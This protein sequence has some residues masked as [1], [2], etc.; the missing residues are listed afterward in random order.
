MERACGDYTILV[1]E[2]NKL[3]LE[4]LLS[5]LNERDYRIAAATTGPKAL[6]IC[7]EILPD[8]I[9]MDVHMPGMDGFETAEQLL[10]SERT[11]HIPILFTSTLSDSKNVVRCFEAG[12]VDYISKPFKK[13]ELLA[14]I[15]THLSLNKLREQLVTDRDNLTS[16]L[17]NMLPSRLINTLKSGRFPKPESVD[18]A[19]VLFTDFKNFSKLSHHIGSRESVEHLNLIYF[20]FD[21]IVECF[22]LERVKTIGDAYFAVGGINT[23]PEN[24]FLSPVLAALKMQ[25]FISYYNAMR[26]DFQWE[27]R[28]GVCTGPVTSGIIGYQKIAYDV[29]GDTVNLANRLENRC[30]PG[31]VAIPE[32]VYERIKPHITTSHMDVIESGAWGSVHLY[33]CNGFSRD[34]PDLHKHL[35]ESIN[36]KLMLEEASNKKSI[37]GKIFS[38]APS[39][40]Q[41]G[42]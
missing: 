26:S 35:Y 15:H 19:A 6:K 31:L 7:N 13:E 24:I 23:T 32:F 34:L 4:L 30:E 14:R 41:N 12:G 29:W 25:E 5:I 42:H 28:V 38:L 18:N 33:Q 27:L 8:L 20:A 3:H 9:L 36:P 22:G 11:Q 21:E 17:H 2:N 40:N 37:L 1:V 10:T 39:Q 16:I